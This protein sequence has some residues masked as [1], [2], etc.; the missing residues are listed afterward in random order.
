[1]TIIGCARNPAR[2][3][4]EQIFKAF[5][6]LGMDEAKIIRIFVSRSE[7]RVSPYAQHCT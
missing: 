7:V 1:M 4:A 2:F 5:A 3:F 6:G